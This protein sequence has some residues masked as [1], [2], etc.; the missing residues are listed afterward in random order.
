MAWDRKW[1][2][3]TSWK[4][5]PKEM[6]VSFIARNFYSVPDRGELSMLEVGYG[7]GANLWY[8]AREGFRVYGVE[9]SPAAAKNAK[10]RLDRECPGW[11]GELHVGDM[12]SLPFAD[13]MFDAVVDRGAT[14][15]NPFQN[16]VAMY[17]E[18][19]R[20]T[21]PRGKIYSDM[22]SVDSY[23]HGNGEHVG[24]NA[25]TNDD[26]MYVRYTD[27]AEIPTLLDG[28][29]DIVV[30]VHDWSVGGAENGKT[31]K[32]WVVTATKPE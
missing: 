23:G 24:H 21:K 19:L 1:D 8:M 30:D 13:G 32:M 11:V 5:Y 27:K 28:W 31:Y 20:V 22:L 14:L 26:G 10:E 15:C 18:M 2:E 17:K 12:E 4:K 25:W 16:A 7:A 3:N 9:G 6:L 29:R